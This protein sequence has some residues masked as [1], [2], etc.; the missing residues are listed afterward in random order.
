MR[1]P[2]LFRQHAALPAGQVSDT[3]PGEAGAEGDLLSAS[4]LA[5]G[6]DD[7]PE[8]SGGRKFREYRHMVRSDASVRGVCRLVQLPVRAAQWTLEPATDSPEARAVRDFVDWVLGVEENDGQLDLSWDELT[9]QALRMVEYGVAVE[10]LVWGDITSWRDADGDEHLVRPLARVADRPPSTIIR[11]PIRAGQVVEVVQN[12]P[13]TRPIPGGKVSHMVYE[14]APG[15][16]DGVAMIR[17]CW[18][19][20]KLKQHIMRLTGVNWDR[21]AVPTPIIYHRDNSEAEQRA[22]EIGRA[23]RSHER[24]Y[25]N[26][27]SLGPSPNG[28]PESDWYIDTLK[29]SLADPV[30]VLQWLCDQ[31]AEAALANFYRQGLGQ[32]GARATAETQ[33]DPFY[34]GVEALAHKVRRERSRQL[35]RRLVQVNF[36]EQAAD[37]LAPRLCVSKIQA[38]NVTVIAQAASLINDAAPGFAAD[39]A[40]VDVFRALLGI[41]QLAETGAATRDQI[42]GAIR[43]LNLPGDVAARIEAALPAVNGGRRPEG[44]GLGL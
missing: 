12:L 34:L 2:A 25:I 30:A 18:G 10:E 26:F 20:W 19:A 41:P 13:Q 23:L 1:R 5:G 17:P 40:A 8:L 39:P 27:P 15:A 11:M 7:N 35:I 37:Q 3:Q 22:K 16:W 31:I 4:L 32:T 43:G 6:P 29:G 14:R 38:D 44:Q 9:E 21:F 28:Q 24:A 42:M 36:G 33:I